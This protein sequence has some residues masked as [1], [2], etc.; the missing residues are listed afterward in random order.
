MAL[1]AIP[2]NS[3][4]ILGTSAVM[5]QMPPS[6]ASTLLTARER[7][8]KHVDVVA[9]FLL[10]LLQGQLPASG[11]GPMVANRTGVTQLLLFIVKKIIQQ[12]NAFG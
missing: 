10:P 7:K 3:P 11:Y 12:D 5:L 6:L 4:C 8:E 1:W 2:R 9:S